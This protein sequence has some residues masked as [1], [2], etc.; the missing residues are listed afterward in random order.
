MREFLLLFSA[1]LLA[2][3]PPGERWYGSGGGFFPL[4]EGYQWVDSEGGDASLELGPA[5]AVFAPRIKWRRRLSGS[6]WG[7]LW[8]FKL[9][10][11]LYVRVSV[12]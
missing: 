4:A 12:V 8:D 9:Y 11:Y 10:L 6:F 5:R 2:L 1:V 7:F 3:G